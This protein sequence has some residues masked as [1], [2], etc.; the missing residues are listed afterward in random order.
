MEP[1]NEGYSLE[2][3]VEG[4]SRHLGAPILRSDLAKEI[5]E[6]RRGG[7]WN[8]NG[9]TAKTLVKY[10]SLR[11]VM[12]LLKRGARLEGQK[13]ANRLSIHTLEGHVRVRLAEQAVDLPAG[14]LVSLE[15]LLTHDV[16]ALEDSAALLTLAV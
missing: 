12:V 11:V 8:A 3:H 14:C 1:V 5:D 7:P 9:H 2:H 16:E 13:S 6:L 10:P 4:E 15:R